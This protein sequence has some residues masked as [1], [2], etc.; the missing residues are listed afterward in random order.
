MMSGKIENSNGVTNSIQISKL[1]PVTTGNFSQSTPFLLKNITDEN[2]TVEVQL[3]NMPSTITTVLYPGWN[4]ELVIKVNNA[5]AD[6]LQ[7]GF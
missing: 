2:L 7:Y 5:V 1:G 6:Q 3:A 4:P